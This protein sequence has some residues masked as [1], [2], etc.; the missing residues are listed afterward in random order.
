MKLYGE[1][2][3]YAFIAAFYSL[4]RRKLIIFRNLYF[5]DISIMWIYYYNGLDVHGPN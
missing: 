3:I 4:Y 5:Y 2:Q 1:M